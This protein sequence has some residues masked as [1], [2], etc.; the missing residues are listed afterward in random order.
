MGIKNSNE[1]FYFIMY[2]MQVRV[3][4]VLRVRLHPRFERCGWGDEDACGPSAGW[5]VRVRFR[6]RS[7]VWLLKG[8]PA[9]QNTFAPCFLYT[10]GFAQ[11]HGRFVQCWG[12]CPQ[13]N[14]V[15]MCSGATQNRT[16]PNPGIDTRD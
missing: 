2:C 7:D 9:N 6:S 16:A 14:G 11:T 3:R 8:A 15:A 4:Q 10:V 1:A 5:A 13:F 12:L